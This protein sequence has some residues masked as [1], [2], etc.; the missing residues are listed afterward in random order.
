VKKAIF[1]LNLKIS[2][3]NDAEVI[4]KR[5]ELRKIVDAGADLEDN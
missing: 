3:N 5:D 1:L 2:M 4:E